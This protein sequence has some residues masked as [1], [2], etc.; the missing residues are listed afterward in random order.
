MIQLIA[1]KK[2]DVHR[3]HCILQMKVNEQRPDI[4]WFLKKLGR[5]GLSSGE[6]QNIEDYLEYLG[7]MRDGDIT[8]DGKNAKETNQVM[9]PEAGLYEISYV[10]DKIFGSRIVNYMRKRPRDILEG[11]T[12]EFEEFDI[13]DEKVHQVQFLPNVQDDMIWLKFQR[14]RNAIPK[15]IHSGTLESIVSISYESGKDTMMSFH[16]TLNNRKINHEEA[17]RNFNPNSNLSIWLKEWNASAE[18]IDM[19]YEEAKSNPATIHG[20]KVSKSLQGI[21]LQM[22]DI[23]DNGDWTV[24]MTLSAVP[25]SQKDADKWIYHLITDDVM[26]NARYLSLSQLEELELDLIEDTPLKRKFPKLF[27]KGPHLLDLMSKDDEILEAYQR[28]IAVED[29][30]PSFNIGED[31]A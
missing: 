10:I 7:L 30:T 6:E 14:Q 28:I 24:D 17:I 21:S 3:I 20:F 23:T 4:V 12:Q 27:L 8:N 25:K 1:T 19:S 29:L 2:I 13:F 9:I 31:E 16:M 26:K 22:G 5:W 15:V 11:N 18:A